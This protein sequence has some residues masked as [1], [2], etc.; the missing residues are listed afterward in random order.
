MCPKTVFLLDDDDAVRESTAMLLEAHG[1]KVQEFSSGAQLLEKT[2]GEGADLLLFDLH[3][4]GLN[5]IEL[6]ELLRSRGILSPAIIVTGRFDPALAE[7]MKK[8]GVATVLQKP[9][10]TADLL[11]WFD[12]VTTSTRCTSAAACANA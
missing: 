10:E 5:G 6:L 9:V 4:A 7:R 3:M 1:L 11:A 8:A 12:R 2:G